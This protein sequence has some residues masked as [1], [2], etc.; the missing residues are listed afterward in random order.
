MLEALRPLYAHLPNQK[1]H[2][3]HLVSLLQGLLEASMARNHSTTWSI[4]TAHFCDGFLLP[5]FEIILLAKLFQVS[6]I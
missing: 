1:V 5:G 4:D 2:T 6:G 3:C